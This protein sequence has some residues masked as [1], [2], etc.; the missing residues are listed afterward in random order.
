[1]SDQQ[2]VELNRF[3][4]Y[5]W[6]QPWLWPVRTFIEPRWNQRL[7]RVVHWCFVL[8]AVACVG[9]GTFGQIDDRRRHADEVAAAKAWDYNHTARVTPPIN[10]PVG[11]VPEAVAPAPDFSDT[12]RP[13]VEKKGVLPLLIGAAFAFACLLIGR[14]FRYILGGE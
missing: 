9:A 7:G 11:H 1:M 13:Y 2:A 4:A 3:T 12:M 10:Y 8:L 6:L 5:G 14:G